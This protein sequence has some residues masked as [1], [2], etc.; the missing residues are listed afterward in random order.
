MVFLLRKD[1]KL[2]MPNPYYFNWL[3]TCTR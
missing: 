2:Q 1:I 3:A